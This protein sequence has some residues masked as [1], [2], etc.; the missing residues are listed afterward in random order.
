MRR[1]TVTY[2]T[3]ADFANRDTCSFIT[4][5]DAFRKI[6]LQAAKKKPRK[7]TEHGKRLLPRAPIS[8]VIVF[9]TRRELWEMI[10]RGELRTGGGEGGGEDVNSILNT[11]FLLY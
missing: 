5:N 1:N 7:L 6:L 11:C 10:G 2:W 4:L 9:F 8:N 3:A